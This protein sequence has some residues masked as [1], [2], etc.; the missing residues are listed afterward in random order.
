MASAKAKLKAEVANSYLNWL[1]WILD[2]LCFMLIYTI[3]F[4][5]VFNSKESYFCIFIF[6]G[7]S[8]WD[9]M[10]KTLVSSVKSVKLNKAVVSRAYFPKY[11]LIL[12]KV[13]INGFKMLISFGVVGV[14]MIIFRVPVSWNIL[15]FIPILLTLGLFTFGCACFLLHYGVYVEDLSNVL[16]VV[17]RFVF[18]ATGIF[19]NVSTRIPKF[20]ELLN[21][22]NPMAFL[23][24]AMRQ[25]LLY[26]QRP[27]LGI[28]AA[29]FGFSL[30][31]ALAG[32]RKIY[33]AENSYV[34]AI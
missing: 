13:W 24:S 12:I 23:I 15:Y 28:L 26:G 10:N 31:L 5:Y 1:W 2:P 20:G 21:K 8:M 11:I 9:F 7:I 3:V 19:Y 34:K 22:I 6:I 18:Y 33:K 25:G 4:G 30:L 16:N 32:I 27:D 17:L 29:W 14:M